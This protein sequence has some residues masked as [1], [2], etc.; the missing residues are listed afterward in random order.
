LEF[1][2]SPRYVALLLYGVCTVGAVLSLLPIVV[3]QQYAGVVVVAFGLATWLG[4]HCLRYVEFEAASRFL[5]NRLRPML[6][7]HVLLERLERTLHSASTIGECWD[8]VE[9]AARSLGYSEVNA[10]LAGTRY[11]KARPS[12]HHGTY[13][14][15]RLNLP[16]GDYVNITQRDGASRNPILVIPF[17]ELLSR[18]LSAKLDSMQVQWPA[19]EPQNSRTTSVMSSDWATPSVNP[20]TPS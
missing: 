19:V 4:V 3:R 9:D 1:G 20:A 12:I 16:G 10:R 7:G 6:R 8:A 15:M 17:V 18:I 2:F 14:Q 5:W 13:W 11:S